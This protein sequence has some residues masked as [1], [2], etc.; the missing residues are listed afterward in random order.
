MRSRASRPWALILAGGDGLRLRPLTRQITGDLRP[1]QYCPILD[2]ETLLDSTRRRA[3]LVAPST[4]HVIVVTRGHEPYYHELLPALPP[5]RLVVQPANRG[6]GPGIL[7]PLLRIV[8]TAGDVPLVIL[9]SDHYVSDDRALGHHLEAALV[10][11]AQRRDV[12]VLLGMEASRPET[13][14][15]WIEPA[16]VALPS[17]GPSLFPIRR[18]LEKPSTAVAEHLL[19]RGCLWNSFVMVG[20]VRTFLRL[21]WDNAPVLFKEFQPLRQARSVSEA[22]SVVDHIYARIGS[23][24]FSERVLGSGTRHLVALPVKGVTWSDLDEPARV[25]STLRGAGIVPSWLSRGL[26]VAV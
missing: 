12:V 10:A 2:G 16:P 3:E 21:I 19:T 14:Y 9:P 1:K 17:D 25:L 4:R 22:A 5:E 7:Y 6:T 15:G 26:G 13:D 20:F 8:A 23:V 11:A 18:F 24:S